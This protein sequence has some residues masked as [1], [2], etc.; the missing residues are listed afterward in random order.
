MV[1]QGTLGAGPGLG[2][3][4]RGQH[5]EREPGV[6]EFVRQGFGS[7]LA[8]LHDRV[9]ADLPGMGNALLQGGEGLAL[10]KVRDGHPVTRGAE[11][12]CELADPV[13]EALRVMEHDDVGHGCSL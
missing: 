13:G 4:L 8:A 9:E 6:D 7:G 12:V 2:E 5:P 10:V 11:L 3:H 1:Q